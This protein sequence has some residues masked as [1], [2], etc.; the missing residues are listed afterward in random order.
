MTGPITLGRM[1]AK[2]MGYAKFP[3]IEQTHG[4]KICTTTLKKI[5]TDKKHPPKSVSNSKGA[6][7][8]DTI[9]RLYMDKNVNQAKQHK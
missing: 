4:F 9:P 5:F 7:T 1:Q 6:H 8:A 2:A 3:Q